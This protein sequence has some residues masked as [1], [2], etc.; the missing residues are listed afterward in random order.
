MEPANAPLDSPWRPRDLEQRDGRIL[1]FGNHFGTARIFRYV[2]QGTFDA[3][4]WS[5]VENKQKFIGQVVTGKAP[6]RSCEDV[7][8]TALSFA[9]VKALATGD[10]RI[11]EKMDLDIQVSKLRMLQSS[12]ANQKYELEDNLLKHYPQEIQSTKEQIAGLEADAKCAIEHSQQDADHFTMMVRGK[13]LSDKKTAG[14]AII[15]AC[16]QMKSADGAVPLGE[17]RGFL[18]QLSIDSFEKVFKLSLRHQLSRTVDIGAD[19]LGNIT[20][21]DNALAGIP[22][23][24]TGVRDH[25]ADLQQQMEI[26]R[27][28]VAKPFPQE[29]EL[30]EKTARLQALNVLLSVDDKEPKSSAETDRSMDAGKSARHIRYHNA[31]LER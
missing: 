12:Y 29:Q 15:A 6:A 17:Y 8:G 24:L 1:R 22:K 20:R 27:E 3:Y 13:T 26:A 2:T 11:K 16:Q 21:M 30:A 19:A 18:L 4:N 9:E 5:L 10:P 14:E 7:D 23:R 28:E 25:L 31:R